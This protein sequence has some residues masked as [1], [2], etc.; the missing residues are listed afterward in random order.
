MNSTS[1]KIIFITGS[2][3]GIGFGLAKDFLSNGNE[4]IL[5]GKNIRKLRR[6][7][8]SLN[9]CFYVKADLSREKQIKSAINKIKK[10]FKKID[11]LICNYGS[12]Q[13]KKNNFNFSYALNNNFFPTVNTIKYAL[14]IMK[15]DYS[16]IICISSIC[17]I[18]VI[19]NAPIGYS[20][21]KSALNSF[22]KSISFFLSKRN[23]SINIIAP[24]NILFK[25]SSWDKKIKKNKS[26]TYK[27]INN[28]V[29]LKKFGNIENIFNLCKYLFF[30]QNFSTG[31]TY[32]VDGGQTRTFY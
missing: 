29:P 31:A 6:A 32:V 24:G 7:S 19:K 30:D 25:M 10:K 17:G 13:F 16:K 22:V 27:F 4:V 28:N 15:N 12:S 3:S 2:S 21:A 14:P 5:C 18:E 1:K 23:I 26:K 8:K 11:F 20:V 9:D